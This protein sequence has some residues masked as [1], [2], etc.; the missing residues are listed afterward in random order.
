[1]EIYNLLT[2]AIRT[3]DDNKETKINTIIMEKKR[4]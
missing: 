2:I 1:M 3:G 4:I